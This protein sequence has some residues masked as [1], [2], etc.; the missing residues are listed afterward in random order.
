MLRRAKRSKNEVTAAKEKE[1][2]VRGGGGGRVEG[3]RG[4]IIS[5]VRCWPQLA[6]HSGRMP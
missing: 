3:R 6:M 1:E 4:G 2:E 5:N